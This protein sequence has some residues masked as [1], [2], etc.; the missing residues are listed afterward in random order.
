MET[1]RE[2]LNFAAA[3]PYEIGLAGSS[4]YSTIV[5]SLCS[6]EA[7]AAHTRAERLRRISKNTELA[8]VVSNEPIG[9]LARLGLA[10]ARA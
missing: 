4:S 1:P 6:A 2:R 5:S 10:R 7:L 8:G 3:S 9:A